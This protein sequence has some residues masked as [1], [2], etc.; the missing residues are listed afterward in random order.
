MIEDIRGRKADGAQ[1]DGDLI[2]T[3]ALWYLNPP[4]R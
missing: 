2:L 1:V 3:I 4:K